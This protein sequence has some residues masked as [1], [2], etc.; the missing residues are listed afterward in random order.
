MNISEYD[1]LS[2]EISL[3]EEMLAQLSEEE[4]IER[5]GLEHRLEMAKF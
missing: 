2:S 3:L 4:I 5:I 1:A